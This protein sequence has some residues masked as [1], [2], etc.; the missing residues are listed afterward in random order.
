KN[1]TQTD[2]RKKQPTGRATPF[3][4]VDLERQERC[5]SSE[6]VFGSGKTPDQ[7]LEIA[8]TLKKAGQ[9]VL[10]TRTDAAVYRK[11]KR[12]LPGLRHDVASRIIF[13][14]NPKSPIPKP[15]L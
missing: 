14:H 2:M 5:G 4:R 10:I 7:I 12:D 1:E 13:W 15:Q 11:L 9:S 6:V 3:A 8:R